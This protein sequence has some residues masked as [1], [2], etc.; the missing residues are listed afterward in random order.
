MKL[1]FFIIPLI[2]QHLTTA[3]EAGGF[4]E[5]DLDEARDDP[6][7][8]R[9][10]HFG[11]DEIVKRETAAGRLPES[12]YK[13]PK[14]HSVYTQVVAGIN[15]RLD[16][17][18]SNTKGWLI[19]ATFVVFDQEF[20][21]TTELT[22]YVYDVTTCPK[23]A[24]HDA[25]FDYDSDNCPK[26]FHDIDESELDEDEQLRE[27]FDRGLEAAIAE[28]IKIH[29]LPD[30]DYEVS[31]IHSIFA[32]NLDGDKKLRFLQQGRIIYRFDVSITSCAGLTA[33]LVF[34]VEV[35]GDDFDTTLIA[36]RITVIPDEGLVGDEVCGAGEEGE[37]PGEED[38]RSLL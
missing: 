10:L 33:R 20:S 23:E 38:L 5:M 3:Q 32:K 28:A 6:T 16:V 1:L 2:L 37:I 22:S 12:T 14:V 24:S 29:R 4:T 30:A 36:I 31:E 8:I 35:D 11:V 27:A 21:D 13:I 9:V 25:E 15:Y 26:G 18:I 17:D 7:V 19:R 34:T